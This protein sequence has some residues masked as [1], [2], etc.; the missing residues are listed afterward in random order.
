M[1]RTEK[2]F[3]KLEKSI[4]KNASKAEVDDILIAFSLIKDFF[5]N[6]ERTANALEKLAGK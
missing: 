5:I 2:K 6:M 3:A 4:R 1:S